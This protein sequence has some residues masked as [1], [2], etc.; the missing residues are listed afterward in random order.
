MKF[1]D[2]I[3]KDPMTLAKLKHVDYIRRGGAVARWRG[4]R[5]SDYVARDA[6][7]AQQ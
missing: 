1:I 3:E 5:R 4:E 7:C 2:L 6:R